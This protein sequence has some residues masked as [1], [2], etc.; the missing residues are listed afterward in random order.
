MGNIPVVADVATCFQSLGDV[1]TGN[2]DATSQRWM[3]YSESSVIGSGVRAAIAAGQG[4]MEEAERLGKAMGRATGSALAGGGLLNNLPVFHVLA[5][6]GDSLGDMFAGLEADSANK[7][8]GEYSERSVVGSG[9]RS[10]IA[11]GQG[12][13]EEA[14]RYTL[15]PIPFYHALTS[16][17]S[18]FLSLWHE[19][20]LISSCKAFVPE[21]AIA[22]DWGCRRV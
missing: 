20:Q 7:R 8:W 13:M 12:N 14:R 9:V 6:A 16:L 1:M 11:A 5:T 19:L 17:F 18:A 21:C 4:N 22:L 10:A 2:P 15:S 3:D